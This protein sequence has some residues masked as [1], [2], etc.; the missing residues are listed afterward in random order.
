MCLR[1]IIMPFNAVNRS[2][3]DDIGKIYS[4]CKSALYNKAAEEP[5]QIGAFD[6]EEDV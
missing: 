6:G 2:F 4:L 1:A 5:R 3:V